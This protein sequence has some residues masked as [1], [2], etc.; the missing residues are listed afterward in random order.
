[1]TKPPCQMIDK[2]IPAGAQVDET[3]F[4]AV[5]DDDPPIGPLERRTGDNARFLLFPLMIDPR[6]DP[7]QPRLAIRIRQGNSR[8]HLRN[9][10]CGMERIAF[11]EWPTEP[12]CQRLSDRR[13]AGA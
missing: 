1:M 7:L 8:M 5:A 11:L 10:R 2:D 4:G 13:F 3:C 9:V 6:R 12:V